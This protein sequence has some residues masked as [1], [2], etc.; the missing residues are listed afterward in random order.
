MLPGGW[1]VGYQPCILTPPSHA[2]FSFNSIITLLY[3]LMAPKPASTSTR[4]DLQK[5][6]KQPHASPMSSRPESSDGATKFVTGKPDK[7]LYEEEQNRIKADIDALQLK[8]VCW[9]YLLPP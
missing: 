2:F 8:L 3:F 1:Q 6:K 7:K 9:L 5:P 4:N